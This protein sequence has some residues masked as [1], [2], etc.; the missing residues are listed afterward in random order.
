VQEI[1]NTGKRR[2]GGRT[3]RNSGWRVWLVP[4]VLLGLSA[5]VATLRDQ[6]WKI[7]PMRPAQGSQDYAFGEQALENV[8]PRLVYPYSVVPGGVEDP[9]EVIAA[10]TRDPVV[11]AH[12]AGFQAG[13]ARTVLLT[14]PRMVHVS[15][16]VKDKVYWTRKKVQLKKGEKLITDGK[17][18]LRA[19][20]GNRVS[21]VPKAEVSLEEPPEVASDVPLLP[22][23]LVALAKPADTPAGAP[24]EEKEKEDSAAATVPFVPPMT[25]GGGI[26]PPVI[27]PM[28]GGGGS[29]PGSPS[30]SSGGPS[31]SP[32]GGG[33]PPATPPTNPTSPSPDP[34]PNV[35]P[36]NPPSTDPGS[37]SGTPS[38]P[39]NPSPAP[40]PGTPTDPPP[41]TPGSPT[42]PPSSGPGSP[43]PS[44]P[45]STSPTPST[46]SVTPPPATPP[47]PLEPPLPG[48]PVAPNGTTPPGPGTTPPPTVD[49]P[50]GTPGTTPDPPPMTPVPEPS[51]YLLMGCG[52]AAMAILKRR[53]P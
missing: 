5:G 2:T 9:G 7:I 51:T 15:Y 38:T 48:T 39:S 22:L 1:N 21:D 26:A 14:Q 24:V 12:Y 50:P 52:L 35:P 18:F 45:P 43:S 25:S 42:T 27:I 20:C 31:G 30:G 32:S 41:S 37:P 16:R 53:A 11:R 3:R 10:L 29:V 4:I 34:P 8:R 44:S 28:G 19:R 33:A 47:G 36:T 17:E 46:P 13:Q 40:P 6:G 23:P 49:P